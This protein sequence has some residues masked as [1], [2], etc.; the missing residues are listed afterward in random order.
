MK[1]TIL[2]LLTFIVLFG[3]FLRFYDFTK[4]PPGL[5]ID[6]VSIAL[7][8][9]DI[10]KTGKDQYGVHM[11]LFFESL[12]DWKVP[13]YIYIVTGSMAMFGKNEFAVRF[14]SALFG[15]ATIIVIFFLLEHVLSLA[16][17]TK[18][19]KDTISLLAAGIFALTPWHIHFSRGGFEA[20]VALFFYALG[21]YFAFL[22]WQRKKMW[23][24]ILP[25]LLFLL[26]MYTYDSYRVVIPL[27]AC[28][29]FMVGIQDPTK[30]KGIIIASV[31]LI[32][33]SLPLFLFSLTP[34]GQARFFQAS[35]FVEN[36]Y[37]SG[38][39]KILGDVVIYS[40]NYLSYF[41]LTYLFRFGDQINRHQVNDLG[42]L[43]IWQLPFII[44][45]IYFLLQKKNKLL[46]FL[47]VGILAIGVVPAALAR[48]SPH[49][50]RFLIG[51]MP[52]AV[53]TAL[54]IYQLILQKKAWI[55]YL[56][57]GIGIFAIVEIAY[58]LN[59]YYVNYPKEAL[60]D[61]GGACKE[62]ALAMQQEGRV[63]RRIAIDTNLGCIRE[64]FLFFSP[65]SSPLYVAPSWQ[66]PTAWKGQT[67]FVRPNYGN[68]K[69]ENL[70]ENIYLPNINHD[71][72]AQLLKI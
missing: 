70:I 31:L 71:V 42:I 54:G 30:R 52:Y 7:N 36:P 55:R 9:Y 5:Y 19:Q 39:S 8:A 64:Y 12:G 32:V 68:P 22:F 69:P 37:A 48:P 38:I 49:S 44:A 15:T 20:V 6:E 16:E 25:V 47:T 13:G 14:P 27:T 61:W 10:L 56:L 63:F 18:K 4:D 3:G 50:L 58:Y 1:K 33:F 62:T 28:I 35:A 60:I 11:P 66:E 41:S 65:Q 46:T 23:Q 67:L 2:F 57:I 43:Y 72:F 53:L 21:M 34:S 40:R 51:S 24:I 26:A 17:N 29:G 59:Y 45:G